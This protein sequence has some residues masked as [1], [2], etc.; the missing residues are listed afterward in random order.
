MS[1]DCSQSEDAGHLQL[2]WSKWSCRC[3][4]TQEVGENGMLLF[5][6]RAW[7]G[8]RCAVRI[9]VDSGS[10][11][12]RICFHHDSKQP[13]SAA[14]SR[15]SWRI[16]FFPTLRVTGFLQKTFSSVAGSSLIN[17]SCVWKTT[18]NWNHL[19]LLFW[20]A[21]VLSTFGSDCDPFRL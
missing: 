7:G 6:P 3:E 1:C 2:F 19:C 4:S 20:T 16:H 17:C 18:S 14:S 5:L 9:P 13:G 10:Y 11:N 12:H 21:V 15:M 8:W